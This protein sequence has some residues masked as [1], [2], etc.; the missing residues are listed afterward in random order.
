MNCFGGFGAGDHVLDGDDALLALLAAFDDDGG[1]V[2]AVG[3]F[4]LG[5]HAGRAEIHFGADAG[6]AE[7]GDHRLV[8]RGLVAIHDEDDDGAG[9]VGGREIAG[10]LQRIGE[11]RDADREAGRGDGLAA[12]ARD[13]AIVAAAAT[14]G[15]EDDV[16]A[17]LVGDG[18]GEFDL[19]DGAGV[20]F[21]AADDRGVEDDAIVEAG[22][23]DETE[24]RGKLLR[25]P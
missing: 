17:L 14:D 5:V 2:A 3:V 20:V 12:E 13:E 25:R 11:A 1:G 21:E 23:G 4:H 15:A 9:G 7:L 19:E 18:E 6:V 22:S 24:D 10:E 8:A 16:L